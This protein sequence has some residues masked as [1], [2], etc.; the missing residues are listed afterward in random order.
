MIYRF[1]SIIILMTC[2][3]VS[4][5]SQS[6]DNYFRRPV[7]EEGDNNII[8]QN[9]CGNRLTLMFKPSGTDLEFVYKPN[10]FRRKEFVARNFSNRDNQTLLFPMFSMPDI[11]STDATYEYD[12]FVSR[13][14]INAPSGA[15]NTITT[16]NIPDENAF[17]IS[18]RSP[19]LL[20]FKPYTKFEVT[21][22][23]LTEKFT[24][25]GEEIV[26][27]I[28]FPGIEQNRFRILADG[29]YVLQVL[30]NDVIIIGG[31]ENLYQVNRL[32]H[33]L[34]E[35]NLD[36]LI[37]RN[38]ELIKP[39]LAASSIYC[40]NPDFM[41]VLDINKR[42]IYSMVDEGGATFGALSRC[43]YLI[44]VRDG[45]M[46]TSLMA[47]SGFP[48][49]IPKW[50]SLALN[51]PSIMRRDDG[52]DVPE[53]SQLLGSRWSKSE[54]DG[55][56]YA[57]LSLFTNCQT[58]GNSE[59]LHT[60]G[61]RILLESIDRFLEKT[62]DKDRRMIGSDTRGETS[63]K[64]SPYFGY[65]VV[66]GEMYRNMAK[67]DVS[68]TPILRSYSF[69]NQVNT[70]NLLL[71]ANVLLALN[72]ELDKGR[73]MEYHKLAAELKETIQLKFK[74][75]AGNFNSGFELHADGS[76]KWIP[77]GKDCDY[78]ESAWANSLGP[79]F[80]V[81]EVQLSSAIEIKND[82]EKYRNYG[83]CPW[84]TISRYLYEYGMSSEDY[85]KMLS[86]QIKDALTLTKKYPMKGA[87][88]EYQKQT[89]GWRALP[90]QIGALYYTLSAQIIQS[91]PMGI[92][93]RASNLVDSIQNYKF[94]L[95]VI[96]ARQHGE[97]DVVKSYQINKREMPYSLQIPANMLRNGVNTVEITRCKRTESFRL[98]SSTAELLLCQQEGTKIIFEFTNPVVSQLIFDHADQ[99]KSFRVTDQKGTE[100]A[101]TRTIIQDKLMIEVDTSGDFKVEVQP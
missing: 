30:E 47:R 63:L 35:F 49:F 37:S 94:R 22:G 48:E 82:W 44:W 33:N 4:L 29:T 75:A 83:Y 62:W 55:I 67:D 88:T 86:E 65:D 38:E 31:E 89:E 78:W 59:L 15:K 34:K 14:K 12:P 7:L 54:E 11:L 92:G 70:Y 60:E 99:V 27:F 76:E 81:P 77:F 13:I 61:F 68:N 74:N 101:F 100:L 3:S 45:S 41:K 56:F 8:L 32:C 46:S 71:M 21:D 72:P 19:L 58:T 5:K 2:F 23:L 95:A 96:N 52:T 10:A 26:S 85:E 43:Y 64:S 90:F 18:A 98:Y 50:T 91:M 53:F 57:T 9:R 93:V 73:T 69:Y 42:I 24:E 97:G 16:V 25:R 39:N 36:Q 28:S 17:V 84:N 20:A 40:K 87:V 6:M 66:N 51:N 1:V 80:P 79:Y